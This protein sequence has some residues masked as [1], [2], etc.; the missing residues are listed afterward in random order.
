M[1]NS[2]RS[3]LLFTYLLLIAAILGVVTL[4][5]LVFLIRN[6][7]LA[8]EAEINLTSAANALQRQ[9]LEGLE[10]D[11]STTLT[12]AAT[13]ADELLNARVALFDSVGNLVVDS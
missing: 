5:L 9:Q 7:R 3:R 12:A 11:D 2:I 8:R 4:A 10:S 13:R 6:P 1:F